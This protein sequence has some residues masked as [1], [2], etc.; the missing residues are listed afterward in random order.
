MRLKVI[1]VNIWKGKFLDALIDFLIKEEP[2]IVTMQ[3]LSGG[4]ESNWK[5]ERKDIYPII[6]EVLGQTLGLHGARGITWSVA[7]DPLSYLGNAMFA[8]GTI[9]SENM[10]W[11]KPTQEVP[12]EEWKRDMEFAPYEALDCAVKVDGEEIR[13][14]SAHGAWTESPT[15]TPEKIRQATILKNHLISISGEPFILGG[16]LN[17]PPESKTIRTIAEAAENKTVLPPSM[18]KRTTHPAIHKTAATRP[19]GLLVDYIFTSP[20]WKTIS[21]EAPV[22]AVSDHL[23]VIAVL[24]KAP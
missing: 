12:R 4:R 22:V 3:E 1:Q 6:G 11:L 8:R 20:H 9:L 24:E 23:P 7:E 14:I 21:I 18:I 19:E 13:V 15:D 2:D 10:L 16:D 5:D 17:M